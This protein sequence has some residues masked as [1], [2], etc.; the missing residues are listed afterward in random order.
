MTFLLPGR[1]AS[2]P[3][4]RRGRYRRCAG[5]SPPRLRVVATP[6]SRALPLKSQLSRATSR[7]AEE[8]RSPFRQQRLALSLSLSLSLAR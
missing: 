8:G 7:I 6:R 3:P 1:P 4:R 2:R 5:R